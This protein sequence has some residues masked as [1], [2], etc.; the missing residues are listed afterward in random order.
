MS[1][2]GYILDVQCHKGLTYHFQFENVSP[3]RQSARMSDI[4]NGRL[5]LYGIVYQF[6]ELGFK[7]LIDCHQYIHMLP[8]LLHAEQKTY[9]PDGRHD[10]RPW[11]QS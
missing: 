8:E 6:E 1:S 5:G 2:D 4:E 7:G 3:E 11:V 9:G 10:V